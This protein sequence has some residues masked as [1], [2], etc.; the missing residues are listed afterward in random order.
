M[1]DRHLPPTRI[2]RWSSCWCWC[3]CRCCCCCRSWS[4][5]SC[6]CSCWRG[7]RWRLSWCR[8]STGRRR[9]CPSWQLKGVNF[10][11]GG[12]ID[13][14]ARDNASVPLACISH[15][16]VCSTAS[17]N[18]GASI[19]IVAV[20]ALVAA[21][22]AD[23]PHNRIIGPISTRKPTASLGRSGSRSKQDLSSADLLQ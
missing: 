8:C 11:V 20:Q 5:S 1:V 22:G 15:Q 21:L 12:K 18:D 19:A 14:T 23:H 13:P 10:V 7:C 4:C 9:R 16:F 3:C 17:V 2:P 6:C